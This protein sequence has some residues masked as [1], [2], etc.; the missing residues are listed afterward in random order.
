MTLAVSLA[1]A[2]LFADAQRNE[3]RESLSSWRDDVLKV[4]FPASLAGLRLAGRHTYGRG[5]LD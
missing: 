5:D 4:R 3:G 2:A 1:A